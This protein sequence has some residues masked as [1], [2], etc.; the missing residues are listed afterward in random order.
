M[1]RPARWLLC[2]RVAG[3]GL[4]RPTLVDPR[5]VL[6]IS[7][8]A[9]CGLAQSQTFLIGARTLQGVGAALMLRRPAQS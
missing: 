1:A 8:S 5:I 9:A 3:D 4:G 2:E 7:S 6:F